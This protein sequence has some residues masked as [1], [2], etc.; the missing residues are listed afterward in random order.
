MKAIER[1][2]T[3]K[4]FLVQK[5]DAAGWGLFFVWVGIALLAHV[6][7]GIG[8]LGVGL[9]MLGAQAARKYLGLPVEGFWA[10]VAIVFAVSG[11]W[12]LF[13]P[14]IPGGLWPIISIAVGMV[15]LVFAVLRKRG[16]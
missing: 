14:M 6:G 9:I 1:D 16:D 13:E 11:V 3:A 5:L 4:H 10:V 8:L 2:H 12:E 15:L 7:W